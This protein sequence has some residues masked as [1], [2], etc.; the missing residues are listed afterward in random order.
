MPSEFGKATHLRAAFVLANVVAFIL[1]LGTFWHLK[2]SSSLSERT[3]P[4]LLLTTKPAE[5]LTAPDEYNNL[6]P[7]QPTKCVE[8]FSSRYLEDLRDH[9]V[10][11]CSQNPNSPVNITCFHSHS[12][13][14][15]QVDSMCIGQG[16]TFDVGSMKF[17]APCSFRSLAAEEQRNGLI[18]FHRIRSYW[19]NTG[20][21]EVFDRAVDLRLAV[22]GLPPLKV[23]QET[24]DTQAEEQVIDH[25]N[26]AAS[27]LA[28]LPKNFVL[29]KREGEMNPWHCLMEIFSTW[30]T[31]DV[32]RISPD[33]R[34]NMNPFFRFPEDV[35]DTQ[36]VIL[37]H[38]PNGPFFDLWTLFARRKPLRLKELANT[39]SNASVT[40][41]DN[42]NFIAPLAGSANPFWQEDA[43]V[44]QCT[45]APTLS[46]FSR[47]VLAFHDIQD[48]PIR[49]ANQSM[50][51]TFVDRRSHRRLR[52]QTALFR[53]LELRH[54]QITIRLVD[55]A[56]ISFA[57]QLRV[58]RETD[59]LVGVHGAG[60]THTM[61]MREGAG[62]IVEMQPEGLE[63][64]GFRIL[65]NM[66]GLTYF[67]VHAF[68]VLPKS[69]KRN[70]Q[71]RSLSSSSSHGSQHERCNVAKRG[72]WHWN[73]V[74]IE[75]DRFLGVMDTAI[76]SM[77][78]KGL[79]DYDVN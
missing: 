36:V 28:S 17:R 57:Q 26:P 78:A 69:G 20:P 9:A 21:P 27:K 64:R 19:Y 63:H 73:D 50:V 43:E 67:H 5:Y 3:A 68:S 4:L 48:P 76:K 49:Q 55:F 66:R 32:L 74:E 53:A 46:V 39:L 12:R 2:T 71:R 56:A 33:S 16:T 41:I 13:S 79:W 35:S 58:A 1:L 30:M 7:P 59:I 72:D 29:L 11:Y 23:V 40:A 70:Q 8:R 75:E 44:Q 37:D 45:L 6:L 38:L 14:D 52:N 42:V 51:V 24:T 31:F 54:P 77:Y 62:A 60:L 61:F 10:S 25:A 15:G 22:H 34:R 18:P 47:R 65:A